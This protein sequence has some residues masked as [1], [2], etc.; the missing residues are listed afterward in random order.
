M[1]GN[2]ITTQNWNHTHYNSNNLKAI[3]SIGASPE[4]PEKDFIYFVTVIDENNNELLQ[5]EFMTDEK[6]CSYINTKY[7]N[8]W[9]FIDLTA[10]K[11]S[12]SGCS[13]CV[14]H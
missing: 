12:E 10:D 3:V 7:Q 9:D 2:R 4:I 5:E 1:F 6:A 11:T 14:A 13:T 8:I